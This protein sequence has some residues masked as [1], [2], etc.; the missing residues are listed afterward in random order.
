MY[1]VKIVL[2]QQGLTAGVTG[3]IAGLGEPAKTIAQTL[4]DSAPNLVVQG[5]FALQVKAAMGLSDEQYQ[6]L[7]DAALALPL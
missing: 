2:A 5:D 1:R 3:Y 4:W 6:A 7:I